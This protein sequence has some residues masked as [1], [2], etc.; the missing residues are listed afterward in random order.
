MDRLSTLD[1]D[2]LGTTGWVTGVEVEG[3]SHRSRCRVSVSMGLQSY[4]LCD[5]VG[6][7]FYS[8][9]SDSTTFCDHY[10][11]GAQPT[12]H[13]DEHAR[14]SV[15]AHEMLTA[16]VYTDSQ[17]QDMHS[18]VSMLL[19]GSI[20][21]ALFGTLFSV[22]F[23]CCSCRCLSASRQRKKELKA[24]AASQNRLYGTPAVATLNG[25]AVTGPVVPTSMLPIR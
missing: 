3:E 5:T 23:C 11:I 16:C 7:L 22:C 10:S 14:C 17:K 18:A 20:A 19:L 15:S 13:F 24:R 6:C 1:P 25:M 8:S 21:L 2:G 12:L 9:S 4:N